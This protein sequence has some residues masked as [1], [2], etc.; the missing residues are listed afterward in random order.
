MLLGIFH[1]RE[2]LASRF[3]GM[4]SL[5][6]PSATRAKL[7]EHSHDFS[8]GALDCSDPPGSLDSVQRIALGKHFAAASAR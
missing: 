7:A 6:I 3:V 5:A 8:L 4:D 2:N 1:L